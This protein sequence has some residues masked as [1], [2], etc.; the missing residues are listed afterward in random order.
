[1]TM[2]WEPSRDDQANPPGPRWSWCRGIPGLVAG[3]VMLGAFLFVSPTSAA[4]GQITEFSIPTPKSAP[5]SIATGADGNLWF[6]E[7]NTDKVGRITPTGQ[8]SEY[9]L[10]EPQSDPGEITAGP[11]G[12]LW[13]C[14][15]KAIAKITT[16]GQV[17]EYHLP[18]GGGCNHIAAGP[19]GNLWFTESEGDPPPQY[20][21]LGRIAPEGQ[22]A[23]FQLPEPG[24]EP[25]SITAGPEGNIWFTERGGY[26][27]V[28][29]GLIGQGKVAR[30][31]PQG[32]VTTFSTPNAKSDPGAITLGPD[33]NLW[34]A[35]RASDEIAR[36]SPS[37]AEFT[38]FPLASGNRVLSQIITGPDGNLWFTGGEG[39][40]RVTAT[41]LVTEFP[42]GD[43]TSGIT[44]GPD[45]NMWFTES[46]ENAIG[47]IEPGLLAVGIVSAA[48][49][50][51]NGKA[52]I[53]LICGGGK[54]KTACQGQLSLKLRATTS[55]SGQ[56]RP[57][58]G[59]LLGR[60]PYVVRSGGSKAVTLVLKQSAVTVLR[61]R[62]HLS[63]TAVA[64]V[65]NGRGTSKA[66][67]L[68]SAKSL[69]H[70]KLR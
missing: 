22:V 18:G 9:Q 28:K 20:S 54:K 51:R 23:F 30:S 6:T 40:G 63:T 24:Q 25:S 62:G 46:Y 19:D 42:T 8:I 36:I 7:A 53:D 66:I 26:N 67:V 35:E 59:L 33:G 56:R 43:G 44:A 38:E 21:Y 48:V 13:F 61:R 45:G 52:R 32:E 10:P 27:T 2:G 64:T 15:E 57:A 1:M 17:T 65:V 39:I 3:F 70:S 31:T 55:A 34:F 29:L 5:D 16:A 69:S 58:K 41:G 4:P 14:V 60:Q 50:S 12:E 37:F 68:R 11:D 49:T 47:R